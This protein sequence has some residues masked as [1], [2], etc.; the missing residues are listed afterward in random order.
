LTI[1]EKVHG[2]AGATLSILFF[3][4]GL[5]VAAFQAVAGRGMASRPA[6]AIGAI[7][8]LAGGTLGGYV[9]WQWTTPHDAT[10]KVGLD[11]IGTGLGMAA[12]LGTGAALAWGTRGGLRL[13]STGSVALIAATG[14]GGMVLGNY[15]ANQVR[16]R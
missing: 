13:A 9:G 8:A 14:L 16:S 2:A 1:G 6:M 12:G 4:S 10:R 15:L 7:G 5:A 11:L 3:G